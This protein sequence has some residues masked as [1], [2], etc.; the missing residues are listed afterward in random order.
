MRQS[1]LPRPP[2]MHRRDFMK[3][4]AASALMSAAGGVAHAASAPA[5]GAEVFASSSLRQSGGEGGPMTTSSIRKPMIGFMLAHE[6]FP[7]PELVE[8]GAMA[9]QAGFD[10]TRI[11]I[12]KRQAA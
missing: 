5:G 10:P 2:V 8:L 6:Q 12:P 11:Q 3:Y 9:E 4:A 1:T 7:V